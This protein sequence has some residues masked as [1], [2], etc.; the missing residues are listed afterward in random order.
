MHDVL[1]VGGGPTGLAAAIAAAEAGRKVMV[2]ERKA[3]TLD[4]AC[5]EGLM[6][7]AVGDLLDLG[8]AAP[9]H[10]PFE[11]IR[12]VHG[13]NTAT[14][15]FS[16]G[17]GWGVRRLAL[18]DA[19]RA[20]AAEVGVTM[21][22]GRAH[23]LRQTADDVSIAV[24]DAR[25]RGRWLLA[26]DGL[27]SPI[28]RSLGL[29]RPSRW[30]VRLGQ[31][32]HFRT[33]PWSPYVEVHWTDTVEAYV[34]PVSEDTVGIAVL[35]RRSDHSGPTDLTTLLRELPELRARLGEPASTRRGAGPFA[36]DVSKRVVGRVLLVG[37]AAG[38][39]DPLT[40]EGLR[41]GFATA[42]AAVAA[43]VS[44]T[45]EAYARAWWGITRRYRV[46]TG[47]LLLATGSPFVRRW[48]VPVLAHVPTLMAATVGLLD[49]GGMQRVPAR[50]AVAAR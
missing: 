10:R 35:Y 45:P 42:R 38:Y 50:L 39:L 23:D 11:G 27:R 12:Y 7:G 21:V 37:D 25:L 43:V 15:H 32:Q 41:L 49:E 28:R 1:V 3:G 18:H 40:G 24:G 48:M 20:R 22:Y 31:R 16:E 4:K 46:L 33:P 47:G 19:L 5:G 44:E 13:E 30:P 36:Q 2:I 9:E 17:V 6:P 14:A 29:E 26:A 8:V 34:T